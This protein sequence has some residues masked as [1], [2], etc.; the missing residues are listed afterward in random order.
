MSGL[1]PCFAR[2]G[3]EPLPF[4]DRDELDRMADEYQDPIEAIAYRAGRM[5]EHY[6]AIGAAWDQHGQRQASGVAED[7]AADFERIKRAAERAR[8]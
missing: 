1:G 4:L 8:G 7:A 5:V 3:T 2:S 6:R